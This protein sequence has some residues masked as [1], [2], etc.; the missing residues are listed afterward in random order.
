MKSLQVVLRNEFI[1]NSLGH[2]KTTIN[3]DDEIKKL[4][5]EGY[6]IKSINTES[7]NFQE[8]RYHSAQNTDVLIYFVEIYIFELHQNI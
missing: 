6:I 4:I 1:V 8:A 7:R 2:K 3:I 5:K